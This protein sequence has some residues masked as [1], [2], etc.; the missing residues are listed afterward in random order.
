MAQK[1]S[2]DTLLEFPCEYPL[3][4]FGN[5]TAGFATHLRELLTPIIG[6][7][8]NDQVD[9]RMSRGNRYLA[10]TI[11]FE[12]TSKDQIHCFD[13]WLLFLAYSTCFQTTK[14]QDFLKPKE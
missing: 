1:T 8:D 4:A 5:N 2:S 7:I 14:L 6:T 11:T 3:K 10:V 9:T 12:A 13:C